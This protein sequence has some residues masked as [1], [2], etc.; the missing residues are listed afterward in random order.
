ML[1][2]TNNSSRSSLDHAIDQEKPVGTTV[3]PK[4]QMAL[5]DSSFLEKIKVVLIV[6]R[7]G[8][9]PFAVS[10]DQR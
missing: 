9:A 8:G 7:F 10:A 4:I 5:S 3:Y 2:V 1:L 6:F